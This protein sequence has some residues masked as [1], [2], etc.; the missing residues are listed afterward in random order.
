MS[1]T[2]RS[3]SPAQLGAALDQAAHSEGVHG[4]SLT[5]SDD[6]VLAQMGGPLA[7]PC[8]VPRVDVGFG[9]TAVSA[10]T[11]SGGHICSWRLWR[12]GTLR[13]QQGSL[14]ESSKRQPATAAGAGSRGR[15]LRRPRSNL[16]AVFTAEVQVAHRLRILLGPSLEPSLSCIEALVC[17][18]SRK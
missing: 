10:A 9:G 15:Q 11:S 14:F 8:N 4:T 13:Q 16:C 3:I 1:A 18:R 6:G 7:T 2:N 12:N 5:K 17:E